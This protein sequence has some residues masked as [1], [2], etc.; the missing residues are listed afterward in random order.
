MTT[1]LLVVDMLNDFLHGVLANPAARAIVEPIS[2]AV[3]GARSRPD[4]AVVYTNDSH[5]PDD[6]ELQVFPPHAMAGTPGAQVIDELAPATGDLVVEKRAYSAFTGTNLEDLLRRGAVERL[7]MV[8]QHTDCCLQHT[9][10]DAFMRGLDIVVCPD[11]S[12]V[13]QPG[14]PEPVERRQE[15]ALQYLRTYYGATL[16]SVTALA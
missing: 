11:A 10:Y 3:D 15:R 14:S 12:A 5:H 13:F 6:L 4:W 1:A 9:S 16:T 2:G 7:V 8:G